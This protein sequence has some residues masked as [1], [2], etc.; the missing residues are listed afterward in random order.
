MERYYYINL[1]FTNDRHNPIK[2][3]EH[4]D[5][6]RYKN[7]YKVTTNWQYN[8]YWDFSN[9]TMLLKRNGNHLRNRSDFTI[10]GN[11]YSISFRYKID[12]DWLFQALINSENICSLSWD[13]GSVDLL[14]HDSLNSTC[15][16]V[17]LLNE[18]FF[19]PIDYI[20]HYEWNH[21]LLSKD[22]DDVLRIFVNGNKYKEKKLRVVNYHFSNLRFGNIEIKDTTN[23]EGPVIEYDELVIVNDCLYKD[24]FEVP[25]QRI[26]QLFPEVTIKDEETIEENPIVKNIIAPFIFGSTKSTI[27]KLNDIPI[28]RR[29]DFKID[30]VQ[31]TKRKQILKYRFDEEER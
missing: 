6:V 5:W 25:T 7:N 31:T 9:N 17:K 3:T 29:S 8:K 1:L 15:I 10:E 16:V 12:K 14:R 22:E 2:D 21:F 27:D 24:N 23:I 20:N 26:H 30:N 19:V 28:I 11:Q 13:N 4:G 18:E